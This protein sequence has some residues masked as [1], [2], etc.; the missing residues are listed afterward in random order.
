[1]QSTSNTTHRTETL[2][3]FILMLTACILFSLERFVAADEGFYLLASKLVMEGKGLYT[4]FFYPQMPGLPYVYGPI[5]KVTGYSWI[6]A[7]VIAAFFT[8]LILVFFF[9]KIL[10]LSGKRILAYSGLMLLLT[11][12]LFIGWSPLAKTYSAST[13]F[14]LLALLL[15]DSEAR[16]KNPMYMLLC[17][18][19]VGVAVNVRLFY[20]VLI[21]IFLA[22]ILLEERSKGV[23]MKT[24]VA[25]LAGGFLTFIPH[26]YYMYIDFDSY[27]FNN[28]GYHLERSHRSPIVDARSRAK[29]TRI[30]FGIQ[31]DPRADGYQFPFL[32]YTTLIY[33]IFQLIRRHKVHISAW[34]AIALFVIHILPDPIHYQYFTAVVPFALMAF[35]L[36]LNELFKTQRTSTRALALVL[37]A[38][39]VGHHLY[40]A[41]Y[42]YNRFTVTGRGVKG[43]SKRN[44]DQATLDATSQ[45]SKKIDQ[46][47]GKDDYVLSLW[48]G[49][50]LESK[51]QIVPGIENQ[52]WL[53][54][55]HKITKDE[56]RK[57]HLLSS[58]EIAGSLSDPKVKV[59][60][61]T[62]QRMK[63]YFSK[64]DLSALGYK[65][66]EDI[67][68]MQIYSRTLRHAR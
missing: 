61:T 32:I 66:E 54:V 35:L 39:I 48:P 5:L 62:P 63:R 21:P 40:L 15:F 28:V 37:L 36:F 65:F 58:K 13:L 43:I 27:W 53:R 11:S 60:L 12:G 38:L 29:L 51:A 26:L 33:V 59:L 23:R 18:I 3:L 44:R 10:N 8:A 67:Y 47:A 20:V 30:L 9:L 14:T 25:F 45:I 41:P 17:G 7:R 4:D 50:L 24:A 2:I 1:M 22:T 57:Y 19:A 64:V 68:G 6:A 49:Y 52:F 16:E 56:R 46:F 42:I 34:I 31:T 55:S